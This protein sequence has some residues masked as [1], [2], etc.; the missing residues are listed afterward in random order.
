MQ[1][2]QVSRWALTDPFANQAEG[3]LPFSIDWR[4]VGY[5]ASVA[6][7]L[8]GQARMEIGPARASRMHGR[9]G[10]AEFHSMFADLA[11][12][13]RDWRLAC[14]GS[15]G[16]A[17]VLPIGLASLAT[18]WRL[19][20]YVVEVDGRGRERAFRPAD[21][22]EPIDHRSLTRTERSELCQGKLR[23]P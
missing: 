13:E 22:I 15:V 16:V 6:T 21:R 1:T 14:F 19:T 5:P 3:V 11:N 7:M 23:I 9:Q 8:G 4:G 12:G 20:P 17:M 18:R 2:A 10:R